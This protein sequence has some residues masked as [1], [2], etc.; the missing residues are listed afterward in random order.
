MS[1]PGEGSGPGVGPCGRGVLERGC[2]W[3]Q[4]GGLWPPGSRWRCRRCPDPPSLRAALGSSE[5]PSEGGSLAKAAAVLDVIQSSSSALGL[6]LA[7]LRHILKIL[8]E[9]PKWE[10]QAGPAQGGLGSGSAG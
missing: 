4:V 3:V 10:Q 1:C 8:E 6:R 5:G 7:G 2:P 9:E